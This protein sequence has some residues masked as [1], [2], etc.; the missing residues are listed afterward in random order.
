LR[1][2]FFFI[3]LATLVLS[4]LG[5]NLVH[6][7]FFKNQRL[8]LIDRQITES[9]TD[10]LNSQEFNQAALNSPFLV[11]DAITKALEGAR[12]GK[13][14]VLRDN[15][16]K[17][18]YESF[19]VGLLKTSL[20]LQP[21]WV[22]FLTDDQYVRI[23]N[24]TIPGP[25]PRILQ[26]GLVLD[27]NFLN[28]EIVDRRVIIY[29]LG[30]IASIFMASIFL[31]LFLLGP[32]RLLIVHL[33]KATTNLMNQQ[34]L[35]SLPIKLSQ[36]TKGSW[37]RSDEFSSLVDSVE[38]LIHRINLNY[39]LTRS[40]TLQ[41]AHEL[42]T[43][44]AILLAETEAQS[45][46]GKIPDKFTS[47]IKAEIRHMSE[48][49]GQFLEWAELENSRPQKDL[50]AIRIKS[51]VNS[52]ATR[53]EKLYP[54]RIQL[55]LN[56][57]FSVFANPS[58]LDQLIANLVSNALKYSPPSETIEIITLPMS[59]SIVDHGPGL[60]AEVRERLGE[61][62]NVGSNDNSEKTGNGLGLAWVYTVAKLYNW[63]FEIINGPQGTR[64]V[65]H[66][67]SE[68]G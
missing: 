59:L 33:N 36:Y 41:M 17:I 26:V 31:T 44:L 21:E 53:F 46:A 52:V 15:K 16:S 58:H 43:P 63:K 19:N 56:N 20:P 49:I 9:S 6:V 61:P 11:D 64:A 57:E 18:I 10:L 14:F 42:K 25:Q 4:A 34:S 60:P 27:R 23:R 29:M 65:L 8:K 62:F 45:R 30:I 68:E 7:H 39:K 22:T 67:P 32:L 1:N 55:N 12:I 37:A 51:A 28:W 48:I 50:H 5:I 3:I 24:V 2:R 38:K 66:F 47:E 54:G 35:E 13:V 40:W